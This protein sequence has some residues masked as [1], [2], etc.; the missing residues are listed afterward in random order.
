MLEAHILLIK[1]SQIY[2]N[3]MKCYNNACRY[4]LAD[5]LFSSRYLLKIKNGFCYFWLCIAI[6]LFV[7]APF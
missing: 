5:G 2:P 4:F 1:L 3:A 7:L 6:V